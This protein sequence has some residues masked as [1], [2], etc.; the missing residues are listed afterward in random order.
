[1]NIL[2]YFCKSRKTVLIVY[3]F[4]LILISFF[5]EPWFDEAESWLIARDCSYFDL[6]FRQPHYEGHPALWWLILSVP[7]KLG[8]PYEFSIKSIQC[9]FSIFGEYLLLSK[10]PFPNYIKM[11]LP[12]TYFLFF[13]YGII[14]RPYCIMILGFFLSAITWKN[15]NEKP[16]SFCGSLIILCLSSA[17]GIIVAGGISVAWVIEQVFNRTLFRDTKRLLSMVVLLVTAMILVF[18][19]LPYPDTYAMTMPV[20][21]NGNSFLV[22][23]LLSVFCMPGEA[24]FTSQ[25]TDIPLAEFHPSTFQI[26]DMVIA[27]CLVF[28]LIIRATKD[29]K[30]IMYSFFPFVFLVVFSSKVYFYIHHVG[31]Y[32]LLIVFS[33][34]ISLADADINSGLLDYFKLKNYSIKSITNL[35]FCCLIMLGILN[36][37]SWSIVSSLTDIKENYSGGKELSLFIKQNKLLDYQWGV[38]WRQ[39]WDDGELIYENTRQY[40]GVITEANP[41]L[42][43]SILK[44]KLG[45]TSYV[46]HKVPSTEEMNEDI[47]ALSQSG[48]DYFINVPSKEMRKRLGMKDQ[49]RI[50]NEIT[51]DMIWKCNH[52]IKSIFVVGK[53]SLN[54]CDYKR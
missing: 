6:L 11:I 47:S 22:K 3:S 42:G 37:I 54:C 7:A 30:R 4:L 25:S 17:Y 43:H 51:V 52:N 36:N 9:S 29:R 2:K 20:P 19:I 10:S 34:W 45:G 31:V 49:Y 1:M 8:L 40:D 48:I 23:L 12:F 41:Y 26:I 5:H 13:Q 24:M 39:D 15:R 14:S 18:S 44:D 50:V 46:N 21:K 27:S 28:L 38:I 16:F 33:L 35:L 32:F 53:E